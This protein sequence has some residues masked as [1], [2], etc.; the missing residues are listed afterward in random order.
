MDLRGLEPLN[1][2]HAMQ[3]RYQLRHRPV[4]CIIYTKNLGGWDNRA[5]APRSKTHALVRA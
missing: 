5:I 1:P 3:V 2:L 4:N